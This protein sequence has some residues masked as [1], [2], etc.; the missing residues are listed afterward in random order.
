MWKNLFGKTDPN[1]TLARSMEEL[2]LKQQAN[3]TMLAINDKA[4]WDVDLNQGTIRFTMPDDIVAVAPVQVV[5]TFDTND[6]SWLWGWDHPSVAA[7]QAEAARQCL[8]FGKRHG[9]ADYATRM[10]SCSEADAWQMTALA[11]HLF[12]GTGAYRGPSGTT[13]V[14]MVFGDVTMQ[15]NR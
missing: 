7:P 11:L 5:G 2:Q 9:L 15:K 13:L 10:V 1:A 3:A 8:D 12:K 6:N 4:G 14:F